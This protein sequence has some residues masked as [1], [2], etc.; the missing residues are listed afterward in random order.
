MEKDNSD[1]CYIDE[2]CAALAAE[3]IAEI[4]FDKLREWLGEMGRALPALYAVREEAHILRDDLQSRIAGMLKAIVIADRGKS[5]ADDTAELLD[6]LPSKSAAELIGLYRRT[7]ARF[8]DTFPSGFGM[9]TPRRAP[10]QNERSKPK[11]V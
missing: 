7:Q 1:L 6:H 11:R 4:D 9:I 2:I 8:R 10:F 3:S 5:S